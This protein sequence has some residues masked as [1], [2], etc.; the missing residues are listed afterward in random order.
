MPNHDRRECLATDLVLEIEAAER[1]AVEV[2]NAEQPA[3]G[4]E[5]DD[6]FRPGG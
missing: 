2:E 4:Q 5:R 3:V 1:R 6:E